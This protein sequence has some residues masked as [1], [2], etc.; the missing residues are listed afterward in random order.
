MISHTRYTNTNNT[1]IQMPRASYQ[2]RSTLNHNALPFA[3]AR[4]AMCLRDALPHPTLSPH[5]QPTDTPLFHATPHLRPSPQSPFPLPPPPAPYPSASAMSPSVAPSRALWFAALKPP[6][7][8]VAIT[9]V[10]IGSTA[11]YFDT[12]TFSLPTFLIYL[13]CCILI[14]LWLNL[15]NDVFDFDTGIDRNKKESIVNL[16]GATRVARNAVFAVALLSLAIA[17][18]LPLLIPTEWDGAVFVLFAVA[19]FGGYAYQSPPFRL[20]YYGLG[21]P[22]CFITW[23]L[24]VVAVYY[25]QFRLSNEGLFTAN[26]SL[27][28]RLSFL[29]ERLLSTRYSLL[30]AALLCAF[31][32]MLILLNSHYHQ[33]E[34]DRAAGKKSPVV[35][36]GR[37]KVAQISC[38]AVALFWSVQVL[39]WYMRVIPMLVFLLPL[40]ALPMSIRFCAFV[41]RFYDVNHVIRKAK[42]Y[43]VRFHFVH[44]IAVAIGYAIE[45]RRKYA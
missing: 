43:V 17:A 40:V 33:L 20:G 13:C 15:T 24:G 19:V 3:I 38:A 44:G 32:T 9:P 14:I 18:A 21:E 8:T 26:V 30:P 42:Y 45:A 35:R 22:I 31:P 37:A 4:T 10:A 41:Q 1:Q 2:S 12:G 6:M 7:Y 36:L 23:T 11:C 5:L 29:F 16:C 28:S 34:D 25:A 27:S 39:F